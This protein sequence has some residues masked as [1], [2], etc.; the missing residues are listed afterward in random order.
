MS[1]VPI[2]AQTAEATFGPEQNEQLTHR[3][4][5]VLVVLLAIEG[6]TLLALD[7]LLRVHM[8]VGLMLIPPVLVKL[9]STGYRFARYYLGS[10]AYRAKGPPQLVLRLAA[11]VLV[12]TT[13]TVLAS[14]VWLMVLGR[15]SDTAL[16]VH[17]AAFIVWS[18]VFAVHFLAYSPRVVRSLANAG[19]ARRQA[20]STVL[21]VAVLSA[22]ALG[23]V[24]ALLL[25]PDIRGWIAGG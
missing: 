21:N 3:T 14:G 6:V 17:K 23:A 2:G 4:A 19:R 13:V 1:T 7:Q 20:G 22:V 18:A 8:F 12:L 10:E 11:P 5:V 9:G 25:L 24:T 16:L 15:H